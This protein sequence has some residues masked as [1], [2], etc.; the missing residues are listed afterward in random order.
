MPVAQE[1]IEKMSPIIG[2]DGNTIVKEITKGIRK[3]KTDQI[4]R[5]HCGKTI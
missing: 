2:E 3:S 4:K 1:G 5:K